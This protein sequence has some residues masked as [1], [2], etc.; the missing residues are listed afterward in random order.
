MEARGRTTLPSAL[1][2]F[3]TSAVGVVVKL[4]MIGSSGATLPASI[5]LS[6]SAAI[7]LRWSAGPLE[8]APAAIVGAAATANA[9]HH[10]RYLLRFIFLPLLLTKRCERRGLNVSS[11]P[12]RSP[13]IGVARFDDIPLLSN[14]VARAGE[15]GE[16][17]ANSI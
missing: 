10:Q 15:V 12:F 4:T 5:L 6:K 13:E 17:N 2:A 3:T 1:T 11:S 9:T 8:V 7:L 16:R 14:G